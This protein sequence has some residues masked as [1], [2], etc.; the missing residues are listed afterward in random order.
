MSRVGKFLLSF[1]LFAAVCYGGLVWFV[2]HEVA[3]GINQAVADTPGMT[4]D[5]SNLSVSIFDHTVTLDDVEVAWAGGQHFLAEQLSVLKYD[6]KH[7]VP[8][9]IRAKA[10]DAVI[11][12]TR[13]NLGEYADLLAMIDINALHG[14]IVV[15]YSFD[16]NG[17]SLTFRQLDFNDRVLGDLHLSARLD[18]IDIENLRPEKMVGLKLGQAEFRFTDNR[19]LERTLAV[20]GTSMR[21]SPEETRRQLAG[22]LEGMARHADT[23]G[24]PR[25]S[26]ALFAFR[27][28]VQ[29]AGTLKVSSRPAEPAPLIYLFMGRDF[30]DNLQLLNLTVTAD[31]PVA[32]NN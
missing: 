7:A 12:A 16:P 19:L 8:Y 1:V 15:D 20:L 27:R 4:L 21:L 31:S 14:D 18:N 5:Y 29:H 28:F 26:D 24:N 25:A 9:F 2:H 23:A 17:K 11:S 30:Y 22:E 3:K 32:E 10:R 6:Q 13:A